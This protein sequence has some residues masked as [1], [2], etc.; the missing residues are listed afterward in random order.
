MTESKT[1]Q[2][3][4]SAR[5]LEHMLLVTALPKR[6][7]MCLQMSGVY[8]VRRVRGMSVLWFLV[9]DVFDESPTKVSNATYA[10]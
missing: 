10:Q 4:V 6:V 1:L 5:L 2:T 8:R 9:V 7:G 3:T